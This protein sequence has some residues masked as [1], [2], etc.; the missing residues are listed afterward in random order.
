MK[1]FAL[2]SGLLFLVVYL[3][4]SIVQSDE[5]GVN[6]SYPAF[7]VSSFPL[8]APSYDSVAQGL[9]DAKLINNSRLRYY[10]IVGSFTDI[11][12]AKQMAEKF[13]G[14]FDADIFILPPTNKGYYRI[15]CGSYLT[16]EEADAALTAARQA[17]YPNAWILASSN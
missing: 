12:Q 17:H 8:T 10:L 3:W 2:I 6:V 13:T 1:R 15:S 9:S 4:V 16:S 14:D 11:T 5:N 7:A